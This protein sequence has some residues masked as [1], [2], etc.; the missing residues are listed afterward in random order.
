VKQTYKNIKIVIVDDGSTDGTYEKIKKRYPDIEILK[1]DGNLWWTGAMYK[2]VEHIL[3]YAKEGDFI[4]SL[5]NDTSFDP[6]FIESLVNVSRKYECAIIGSMEKNYF[7]KDEILY[8]GEWLDWDRVIFDVKRGP[9][10][11]ENSICNEK[12]NVLPGRGMLIPIEVFK[13][14][15]NFNKKIFPHYIA[16]Y[17]FTVRA[18][19]AGIKLVLSYKSVIYSRIDLTGISIKEK[20]PLTLKETYINY[21]SIKSDQNIL[22]H[23][24]FIR[25]N[26]PIRYRYK[27]ISKIVLSM[28]LRLTLAALY[29]VLLRKR[30]HKVEKG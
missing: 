21:F 11:D 19:N 8:R 29:S 7:N 22:D 12:V 5:N 10:E 28:V 14:I 6:D 26:C 13:K 23:I 15:G 4:L 3:T 2:G 24:N 16:D 25:M 30:H 20:R 27:H 9:I 18:F 1:G 17:D